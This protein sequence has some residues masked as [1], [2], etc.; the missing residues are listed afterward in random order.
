NKKN[1]LLLQYNCN[2]VLYSGL[3][4][5]WETLVFKL[6]GFCKLILQKDGNL[7]IYTR[8]WEVLWS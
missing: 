3:K 6:D 1:I 7:V 5:I 2:L 8:K 4:K